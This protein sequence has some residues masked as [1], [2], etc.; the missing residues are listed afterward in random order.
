MGFVAN[1][2]S[3]DLTVFNKKSR[4]VFD[5][6]PTGREPGG[7]ALDQRARRLYVALAGED[8][9]EAIDVAA[10]QAADRIRL[11]PGDE[12][13]ELALTPDGRL[14][15]AANRGS[16]TVSLV[17]PA[18][19]FELAK[20]PVGNGP[21]SVTVESGGRRA[22]VCNALSNDITVIDLF[23]RVVIATIPTDP[24]PVRGQ[25]NRRGDRLYVIHELTPYV[26]VINPLTLTV[27]TRVPVRSGMDS[28]KV[29]PGTDIIYLGGRRELA[30][31]AHDPLSMAAVDFLDTGGSVVHMATDG[32]ENTLYLVNPARRRVL[33]F[34]RI[35]RNLVGELD[36]GEEP[37]WVSLMGEN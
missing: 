5:A 25:L 11:T 6:I 7:M 28:I 14:L 15:L 1:R 35:R 24:A 36:T 17:D 20:L 2:G 16:N 21:R 37:G 19:R 18:G 4:Q 33:V 8:G 29:D 13:A 27:L 10:G 31:G 22:F 30:V 34:Q 32:E 3:N 26:T 9:I 12:P 23:S